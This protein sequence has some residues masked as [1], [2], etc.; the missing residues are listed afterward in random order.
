MQL[1]YNT[2]HASQRAAYF[3]VGELN[4]ILSDPAAAKEY[5]N[6][7]RFDTFIYR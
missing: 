7:R 5:D 6:I 2:P 4:K 3:A 1:N